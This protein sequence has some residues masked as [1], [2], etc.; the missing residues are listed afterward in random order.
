MIRV[1]L[2]VV[3]LFYCNP[4]LDASFRSYAHFLQLV[5]CVAGFLVALFKE[6]EEGDEKIHKE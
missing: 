1:D 4:M 3:I 6:Q 2:L 5:V